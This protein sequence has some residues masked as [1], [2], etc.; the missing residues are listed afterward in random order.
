MIASALKS[1]TCKDVD[2]VK[3]GR[4]TCCVQVEAY[5]G[6]HLTAQENNTLPQQHA[7]RITAHL[8]CPA[9]AVF[10]AE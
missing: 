9:T 10:S 1:L 5:I 4:Q 3:L 6:P 7:K 8:L 2:G